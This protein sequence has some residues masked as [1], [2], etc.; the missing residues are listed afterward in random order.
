MLFC[1]FLFLYLFLFFGANKSTHTNH[2]LD[3]QQLEVCLSSERTASKWHHHY[4]TWKYWP[5]MFNLGEKRVLATTW[6]H[7]KVA[8]RAGLDEPGHEDTVITCAEA[9]RRGF[10]V[11]FF[12][13]A[14]VKYCVHFVHSSRP[15]WLTHDLFHSGYMHDCRQYLELQRSTRPKPMRSSRRLRRLRS[16]MW[17][18]TRNGWPLRTTTT[19]FSKTQFPRR[20][21]W[22]SAVLWGRTS[23]RL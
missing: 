18:M 3:V 9:V 7:Y 16:V 15:F 23:M 5:G 21:W 17:S 14:L 12:R 4:S 10:W 6:A 22:G 8:E 19:L 20:K 13:S 11:S 1:F 2:L